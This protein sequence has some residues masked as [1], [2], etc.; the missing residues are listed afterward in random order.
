M[1]EMKKKYA[2][3]CMVAIQQQIRNERNEETICFYMYGINP[4]AN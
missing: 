2:F 4:A 3:I 1:K